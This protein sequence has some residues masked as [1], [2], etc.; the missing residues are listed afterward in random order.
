MI[1]LISQTFC[2]L[3][4]NFIL[5]CQFCQEYQMGSFTN[6]CYQSSSLRTLP[7][8]YF[9]NNMNMVDFTHYHC[10]SFNKMILRLFTHIATVVF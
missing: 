9:T 8:W 4:G 3:T 6:D 2:N 10:G 5:L 7:I 1:H